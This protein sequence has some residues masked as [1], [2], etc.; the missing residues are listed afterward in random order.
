MTNKTLLVSILLATGC[1]ATTP[2]SY[3][4]DGS[5]D[6][7]GSGSG[8]TDPPGS[9]PPGQLYGHVK[10]ERGDTIDFSS[11]EPV[12]THAGAAIDLSSGC[13]A[14]YHY[15]YLDNKTAPKYGRQVTTNPVAFK[16]TSDVASLDPSASAYRVRTEDNHVLLDWT[17]MTAAADGVYAMELHRDDSPTMAVLGTDVGTMFVDARFRDTSGTETVNTGCFEN[18]PLSAPLNVAAPVAGE[19]FGM[20]LQ[21]HSPISKV[22]DG[23]GAIVSSSMIAQQTAEPINIT[24]KGAAPTGTGAQS[25]AEMWIPTSTALSV[26]NCDNIDCEPLTYPTISGSSSGPLSGSSYLAIVDDANNSTLCFASQG[27]DLACTIPAR[28][29]TEAPHGYHLILKRANEKSIDHPNDNFGQ[30]EI[31]INATTYTAERLLD[32]VHCTK[33]HAH[34]D[35]LYCAQTTTYA[36][37]IA[38]DKARIDFDTIT[39]TISAST[40]AATPELVPYLSASTLTFPAKTWDA[41]DAGL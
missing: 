21:A 12:H 28:T 36:H 27:D 34:L 15:A 4:G 5:D 1:G 22:L 7:S 32:V 17:P 8:I 38:V 2:Y 19:L 41:G 3:P 14:V 40:G 39:M 9:H 16:V 13:P 6:G 33:T 31:V 26:V 29:T 25:S 18:H 37:I 20:T 24:I 35:T 10:D 23:F 11:G 30:A